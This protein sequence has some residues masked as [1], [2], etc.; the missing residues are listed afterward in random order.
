MNSI[1]TIKVCECDFIYAQQLLQLCNTVIILINEIDYNSDLM[2][3][4]LNEE[5][6]HN[7]NYTNAAG[8][9]K[10]FFTD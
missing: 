7:K 3:N 8:K 4:Y 2:T 10:T 6:T 1:I 5:R 9:K